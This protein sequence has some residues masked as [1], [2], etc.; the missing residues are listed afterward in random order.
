MKSKREKSD[1]VPNARPLP[2]RAQAPASLAP[3]ELATGRSRARA[4]GGASRAQRRRREHGV[5]WASLCLLVGSAFFALLVSC[6]NGL[7]APTGTDASDEEQSDAIVIQGK[8]PDAGADHIGRDARRDGDRK[9]SEPKDGEADHSKKDGGETGDEKAESDVETDVKPDVRHEAGP[10]PCDTADTPKENPCVITDALG[11]FVAPASNGGSDTTGTGTRSQPYATLSN[12]ITHAV[13]AGKRLYACGATYPEALVVGVALDGVEV[14]GGLE[15][16]SAGDGGVADAGAIDS[17]TGAWSYNGIV[18][19]VAPTT[20][21]YALDVESLT[22][23]AHFE[24][25]SFTA[26]AANAATFGASSIAVLVNG[27][28]SVSFLRV[29]AAAAAG[30]AGAPGA[31]TTSNACATSTQG[32]SAATTLQGGAQG[33]CTCA[34]S[35]S[36]Q[37]GTGGSG[38]LAGGTVG[39]TGS[40]MPPT[41]LMVTFYDGVGG[42]G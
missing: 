8:L 27:S 14:Y 15:C 6:G 20:T 4:L 39:A 25:V 28:V 18:A 22:K 19:A 1:P 10:P 38:G 16:P 31:A 32:G 34:V 37:G 11:V 12:A 23:G 24:D 29:S 17:S 13:T 33:S 3:R 41:T 7:S 35:G 21:G 5:G 30:A 36:S 9:D 2:A 26:L 42:G 40:A